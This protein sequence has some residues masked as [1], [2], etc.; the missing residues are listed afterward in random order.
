MSDEQK[1]DNP[2]SRYSGY[3]ALDNEGGKVGK[4]DVLFT[5]GAGREAYV[6]VGIGFLGNRTIL[7][8]MEMTR[9]NHGEQTLEISDSEGRIRNAPDFDGA[10][11]STTYEDDVRRYFGLETYEVP[12][13][14]RGLEDPAPEN[15][16]YLNAGDSPAPD[17]D[18]ETHRT[19]SEE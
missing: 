10:E 15:P 4:V 6:S 7:I 8:P 19:Y 5:D 17:E 13:A 12:L 14:D 9:K 18:P 3:R 11:I 2:E 16:E 1:L